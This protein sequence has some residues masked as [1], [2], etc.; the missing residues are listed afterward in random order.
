VAV[1]SQEFE[2]REA[3]IRQIDRLVNSHV[4]HGSESLCRMLLYLAHHAVEH[5]GSPV[6]EYQI[7]TEVLG[8][9]P[10][11][12]PHSDAT[13]RV[14]AGRL[15]AKL[16]EYYATQ[17]IEDSIVVELPKGSYA[18]AFHFRGPL[19][20]ATL[21]PELP[22]VG[23][24]A[25]PAIQ[26]TTRNLLLAVLGLSILLVAAI[27]T[28]I[29]SVMA[30][31]AAQPVH[32]LERESV[33][34][35]LQI[36]WSPFLSGPEEPWI[37]FSNAAFVGRPETGMRYYIPSQDSGEHVMDYYTGIG[38]VSAVRDLDHVLSQL[39]RNVRVKRGSLFSL[40]D[41]KSNDLIFVGSPAENL[42]LRELPS[43]G[44]FVFQRPDSGPRK[45][46]LGILNVHPHPGEPIFYLPTPQH[47][48]IDHDYAVVALTRGLNPA[49]STLILAGTST[50]GTQA[51][52]EFVCEPNSVQELLHRLGV[53]T[54]AE[55]KPFEALLQV[56]V[57][58]E[59]PVS[60]KIV[61]L[62]Q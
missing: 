10:D 50:L 26:P 18:L 19:P 21:K 35:A 1:T 9:P 52:V 33:P 56:E 8:R 62:R 32:A 31:K 45:G 20:P 55:L 47:P 37:I 15:R 34:S 23:A 54:A 16:V 41:A 4:L 58:H 6:K 60:A 17:G 22:P 38:E 13:I 49:R 27:A 28:I 59:V 57:K 48:P 24:S 61:T 43:T 46:D 39:K 42:T 44:E 40:D 36:F 3:C 25:K 2:E 11:F 30:R 29:G 51:A 5:P 7:A 53:S 14:Q 12:D